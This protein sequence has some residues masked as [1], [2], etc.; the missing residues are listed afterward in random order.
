MSESGAA[1]TQRRQVRWAFSAANAHGIN[2]AAHLVAAAK[3]HQHIFGELCCGR[4]GVRRASK[5]LPAASGDAENQIIMTHV[6]RVACIAYL[7]CIRRGNWCA[8]A[9]CGHLPFSLLLRVFVRVWARQTSRGGVASRRTYHLPRF[10]GGMNGAAGGWFCD[11]ALWLL[12]GDA[13]IGN[14][15]WRGGWATTW[16]QEGRDGMA[17]CASEPLAMIV[18]LA[19][20]ALFL[21]ALPLPPFFGDTGAFARSAPQA[22]R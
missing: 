10:A 4:G 20:T 3:W 6:T 16:R 12:G 22:A 7:A 2:S 11:T 15:A 8:G 13:Q 1:R 5:A 14:G 19:T 9:C 21:S 18:R 17:A